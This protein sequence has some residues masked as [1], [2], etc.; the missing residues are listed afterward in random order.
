[1][2]IYLFK[3]YPSCIY[4]QTNGIRGIFIRQ[5]STFAIIQTILKACRCDSFQPND[6]GYIPWELN[7][8]PRLYLHC[9]TFPECGR[10][11]PAR[12]PPI[13]RVIPAVRVHVRAVHHACRVLLH[14][15]PDVGG[16]RPGAVVVQ[17]GLGIVLASGEL[18]GVVD[19]FLPEQY[20]PQYFTSPPCFFDSAWTSLIFR[21]NSSNSSGLLNCFLGTII[22]AFEFG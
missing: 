8:R 4:Y 7:S 13:H 2:V 18:V 3:F 9:L 20:F 11:H 6:M 16:V 14:E 1:M 22:H 5:F 19:C 15:P 21:R 10:N 12:V 17:A